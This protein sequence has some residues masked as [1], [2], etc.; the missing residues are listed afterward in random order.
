MYNYPPLRGVSVS[1]CTG[2]GPGGRDCR[3]D[4]AQLSNWK[5]E[6]PARS[7]KKITEPAMIGSSISSAL[8][9]ARNVYIRLVKDK[10]EYY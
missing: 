3:Q 8:R 10:N 9:V 5:P 6:H 7:S 2:S 1:L 4:H